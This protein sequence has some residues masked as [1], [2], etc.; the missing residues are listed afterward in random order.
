M[1]KIKL[2]NRTI[3]QGDPLYFIADI[4][5]NHD[6]DLERAYKLIELS[7]EAGADAAKFQNFTAKKIVSQYGFESLVNKSSHQKNWKKSTVNISDLGIQGR[8]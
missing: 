6:G 8:I 4:G 1:N 5:A 7:K 2:R 3:G